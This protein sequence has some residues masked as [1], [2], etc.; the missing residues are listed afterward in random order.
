MPQGRIGYL[1]NRR[2]DWFFLPLYPLINI[3]RNGTGGCP[4]RC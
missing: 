1:V 4:D 3:W 2:T